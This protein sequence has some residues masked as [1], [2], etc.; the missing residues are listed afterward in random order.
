ME[1]RETD[2]EY[3]QDEGIVASQLDG[4]AGGIMDMIDNT[5]P[6]DGGTVESKGETEEVAKE[7]TEETTEETQEVET[8]EEPQKYQIK[9]QGEEK[10]V[11]QEELI[12]LAQKG[13]DYTKKTQDLATERD[14][15]APYVGLANQIK[16]RPEL[17]QKIAE[18]LTGTQQAPVS[19]DP[20]D[21]FEHKL[22]QEAT[23]IAE[24]KI[25]EAL[26]PIQKQVIVNAVKAE[27]RRDPDFEK[28]QAEM[29]NLIKSQP[30][31]LQEQLA[32]RLNE[33]IPTYLDTFQFIKKKL[34]TETTK[35]T[36]VKK[37]TKTP[38]LEAGGVESPQMA[39]NK[40]KTERISKMKAKALRSGDPSEIGKWLTESGALD[41]LY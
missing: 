31:V 3:P 2:V 35:P 28:V 10:E 15:L 23:A 21:Q 39:E 4:I 5:S 25:K 40:S 11:T 8:P 18:L 36:P 27:V 19:D 24:K 34:A 9:W 7:A 26:D 33:D 13:F 38:I 12:E 30:P 41:H 14:N 29:L 20:V 6:M 32:R 1:A 22:K 17:A 16:A 37:E